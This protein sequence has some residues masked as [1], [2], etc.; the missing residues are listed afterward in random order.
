[1][2]CHQRRRRCALSLGEG[3]PSC[4]PLGGQFYDRM[5]AQKTLEYQREMAAFVEQHPGDDEDEPPVKRQRKS[6]TAAPAPKKSKAAVEPTYLFD[7]EP[8]VASDEEEEEDEDSEEGT[9][10]L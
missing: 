2:R 1:M 4:S 9:P 6:S 3:A 5:H 10:M 7:N 8:L